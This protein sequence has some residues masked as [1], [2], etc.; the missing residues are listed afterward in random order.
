VILATAHNGDEP[1]KEGKI[2]CTACRHI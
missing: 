2:C 1:P